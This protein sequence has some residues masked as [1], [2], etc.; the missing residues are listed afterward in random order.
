MRW[1]CAAGVGWTGGQYQ[2]GAVARGETRGF[3]EARCRAGDETTS[4]PSSTNEINQRKCDRELRHSSAHTVKKERSCEMHH[5]AVDWGCADT[6]CGM[7][8]VHWGLH[9]GSAL[10]LCHVE[11][12]S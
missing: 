8:K 10:E 1:P 4:T 6:T 9:M 7:V 2:L 11:A 5:S 3:D 12:S